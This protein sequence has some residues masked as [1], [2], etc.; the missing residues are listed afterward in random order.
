M[1]HAALQNI[2]DLGPYLS[3]NKAI[4][5]MWVAAFMAFITIYMAGKKAMVPG[6]YQSFMELLLTLIRQ[7]MVLDTMGH[8]G[9]PYFPLIAS[10]FFFVFFCNIVGIFPLAHYGYTATSDINVTATLAVLVFVVVLITGVRKK[11]LLGY[12]KSFAPH[13]VPIFLLPIICPVEVISLFAKHFALA[14]RLFANMLAG[15][16]VLLVFT[17]GAAVLFS[18]GIGWKLLA[19]LPFLGV[20]GML[21]FE[22]FV[23]LIQSFIFAILTSLYIGDSLRE[24]H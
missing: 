1:E 4:I 2:V 23:A 6:R 10:L 15:H 7:K 14:V 5:W 22:I 12:L 8:E 19:P 18:K 24:H 13:G 11:G 20:V 3:I 21:L 9:L 16:Q 17:T